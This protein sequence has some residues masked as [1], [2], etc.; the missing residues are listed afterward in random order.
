M[1]RGFAGPGRGPRALSR[2]PRS[3]LPAR[4][5]RCLSPVSVRATT[6]AGERPTSF[7]EPS[8]SPPPETVQR[9]RGRI[10]S[11][12][13]ALCVLLAARLQAVDELFQE[14]ARR[15][16]AFED[17]EQ[18]RRVLEL[19]RNWASSLGCPGEAA[20]RVFSAI[21]REGK[22]WALAQRSRSPSDLRSAIF[23]L[24]ARELAAIGASRSDEPSA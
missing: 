3:R 12:D 6:Q 14:K 20:D 11:I 19:V 21:I 15:G 17:P 9:I 7:V 5:V 13:R 16:I 24:P 10:A 1:A 22:R 2:T 18:E 4:R 8:A 23:W